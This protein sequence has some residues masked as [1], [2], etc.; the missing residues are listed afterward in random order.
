MNFSVLEVSKD[1]CNEQLLVI[2]AALFL[3]SSRASC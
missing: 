2:A 3:C 1:V